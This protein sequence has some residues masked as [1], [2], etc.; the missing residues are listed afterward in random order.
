[1]L[2]ET[3][4]P[5]EAE[6]EHRAAISIRQK[7]AD[8]NPAVTEFRNWLAQ[9]HDN[10]GWLL[11]GTGKP[12]EAEAEYRRALE[13]FG[14]LS[15]DNPKVAAYRDEEA[16]T[17][18]NLSVVRR[19]LGRPADA[20][21]LCDGPSASARHWSGRIPGC[22]VTAPG[23]PRTSSTAGWPSWPKATGPALR[24]TSGAPRGCTRRSRR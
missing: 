16:N 13:F 14:K 17:G 22:R 1:V 20:G 8:N 19:R 23:W 11:S 9:S 2:E 5:A 3:G 21:A 10:L 6:A 18:N 12:A 24:P 4:K 7:L 15:T